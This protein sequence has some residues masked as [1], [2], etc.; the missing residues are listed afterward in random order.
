MLRAAL[1][2]A[3]GVLYWY[4]T[5]FF[6]EFIYHLVALSFRK[7]PLV[8]L[9]S[10]GGSS[11]F[12]LSLWHTTCKGAQSAAELAE[13]LLLA[14]SAVFRADFSAREPSLISAFF[15]IFFS[16]KIIILGFNDDL[17]VGDPRIVRGQGYVR[18]LVG[19]ARSDMLR[20]SQR[21]TQRKNFC[22]TF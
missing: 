22:T 5:D 10:F 19:R 17:R 2:S 1:N 9:F 14:V 18:V 6:R 4:A 21:L 8:Q 12:F 11:S 13:R 7:Y 16:Q 15:S 3:A 20:D